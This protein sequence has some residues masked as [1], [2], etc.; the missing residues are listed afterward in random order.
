MA[1]VLVSINYKVK[2]G[3]RDEYLTLARQFVAKVNAAQPSV[4]AALFGDEDDDHAFTEIYECPDAASYDALE[5]SYDE[6][7]RGTISK[8]AGCVDGRQHVTVLTKKA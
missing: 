4:S 8:I 3:S 7:I 5:D 6:D 2:T 1:A